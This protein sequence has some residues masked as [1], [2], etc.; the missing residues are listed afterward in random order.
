MSVQ[1]SLENCK[2]ILRR[3]ITE[4]NEETCSKITGYDCNTVNSFIEN[5][6]DKALAHYRR[7]A[8]RQTTKHRKRYG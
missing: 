2:Y 1:N 3:M 5:G 7:E 6:I 8:K 4:A